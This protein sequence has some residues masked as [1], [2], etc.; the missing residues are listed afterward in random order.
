[1]EYD[2]QILWFSSMKEHIASIEENEPA[3]SSTLLGK[4]AID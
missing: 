3:F 4:R 2:P 1:M